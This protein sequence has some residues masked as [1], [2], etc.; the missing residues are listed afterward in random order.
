[1][2]NTE[3]FSKMDPYVVVT[4]NGK[5]YQTHTCAEGGQ[6]PEWNYEMRIP[7]VNPETDLINIKCLEEDIITDDYVGAVDLPVKNFL[8]N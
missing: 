7:I 5:K 4:Y 6:E 1:M 3:E 8:A 2:V